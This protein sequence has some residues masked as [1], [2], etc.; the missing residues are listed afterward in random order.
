VAW[1]LA[2]IGACAWLASPE[3]GVEGTALVLCAALIPVPLLL[4]RA[5]LLWSAPALAPLLGA[6]GLAPLFVGAAALLGRTIWQRAGLAAA[7]LLWLRFAEALTGS[8]L[9]YGS[10]PAVP[11]RAGWESS[12][13]DAAR[14]AIEP[15]ITSFDPILAAAWVGGA[16][17]LGLLAD[18]RRKAALP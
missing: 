6:I 4:P 13:V 14:T 18:G 8:D 2:A 7:G 12:V 9:L 16:V 5:G 1:V 11:P 10:G 3:A 15:V 17:A